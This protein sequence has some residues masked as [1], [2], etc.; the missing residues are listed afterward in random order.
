VAYF[1]PARVRRTYDTVAREYQATFGDDLARLA[2]DRRFLDDVAASLPSGRPALDVGCGPGQVAAHLAERGARMI[3]VDL[4]AR[5]LDLARARCAGVVA[6]ATDIRRL[7]L[8]AGSCAGV[9]SFYS[10]PFVRRHELAGV[11]TEFR[12]VL[13]QGGIL[14]LA[15]HLGSGE[16]YGSDQWLGHVVEPI[17]LTLF[18]EGELCG[19]V[20]RASFRLDEVI[21][22]DPPGPRASG[23]THLHSCHRHRTVDTEL[24]VR[25]RVRLRREGRCAWLPGRCPVV[26]GT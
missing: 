26:Q 20:E 13:C 9:T 8:R 10:L 3:A 17:A 16:I 15:T 2:V 1:D 5:M 12:R 23:V 21:Y 22:R 6:L 11:L 18:E 24:T 14:G 25:E 19:A 4:S 7:G